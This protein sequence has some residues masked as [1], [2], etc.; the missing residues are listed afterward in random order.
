VHYEHGSIL[1]FVENT[2][3]L[4][5]LSASDTRATPPD[6]AFDFN[7]APRPFVGIPAD[8]GANYFKHQ[9]PDRRVP[10]SE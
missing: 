10:D 9:P 8:L 1:R 7:S 4:G 5:Q 3:G 6:D 2:F